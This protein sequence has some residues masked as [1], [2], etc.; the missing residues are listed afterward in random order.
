MERPSIKRRSV[1][2][3]GH[4]TSVSMEDAF[5]DALREIAK[6]RQLTMQELVTSIDLQRKH[7]NLSSAIRLFVLSQYQEQLSKVVRSVR[8]G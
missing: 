6:Q 3:D 7:D 5:W 2:I 8:E 1:V 4:R